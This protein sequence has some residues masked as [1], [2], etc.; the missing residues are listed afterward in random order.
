MQQELKQSIFDLNQIIVEK[1][2]K[3][4]RHDI[5][6]ENVRRSLEIKV[7]E[8][9]NKIES[10]QSEIE[11]HKYQVQELREHSKDICNTISSKATGEQTRLVQQDKR[12]QD[13]QHQ[14]SVLH[15]SHN[16]QLQLIK[17]EHHSQQMELVLGNQNLKREVEDKEN[18]INKL[19]VLNDTL[20]QQKEILEQNLADE[21]AKC[22]KMLDKL[23]YLKGEVENAQ[24]VIDKQRADIKTA[25]AE[26]KQVQSKY[27]QKSEHLVQIELQMQQRQ[28][29]VNEQVRIATEARR[30]QQRREDEVRDLQSQCNVLRT[31]L[32]ES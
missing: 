23:N 3:L 13:L 20:K 9:Q 22:N 15:Q 26:K 16:D 31:K 12:I 5:E 24:K 6:V 21:R 25:K 30:E 7:A 11:V 1:D 28:E 32:D 19:N 18:L 10:L 8:K 17:Q 4:R 27:K 14:L 29:A 2:D